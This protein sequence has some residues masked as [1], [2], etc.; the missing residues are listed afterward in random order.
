MEESRGDGAEAFEEDDRKKREERTQ[1]AGS[2]RLQAAL[3]GRGRERARPFSG[4]IAELAS[5]WTEMNHG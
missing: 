4:P 3:S 1:R 5:G 2:G